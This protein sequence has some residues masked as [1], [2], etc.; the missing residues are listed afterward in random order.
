MM[1]PQPRRRR[2]MPSRRYP[3]QIDRLSRPKAELL[4]KCLGIVKLINE[5]DYEFL[6][7][8]I[9]SKIREI[10]ADARELNIFE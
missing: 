10:L 1:E 7:P 2:A 5:A 9:R 3:R 8:H 4:V 6:P